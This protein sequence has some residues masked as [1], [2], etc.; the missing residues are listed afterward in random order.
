MVSAGSGSVP[1]AKKKVPAPAPFLGGSSAEFR[2]FF[3]QNREVP[4]PPRKFRHLLSSGS[5][6][7]PEPEPEEPEDPE[8]H[9]GDP[10]LPFSG[11]VPSPHGDSWR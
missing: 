7:E 11:A 3:A 2:L 4:A 6:E 8:P 5:A 1:R 9:S 10:L